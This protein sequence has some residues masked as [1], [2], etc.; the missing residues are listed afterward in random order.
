[1]I[2]PTDDIGGAP[3]NDLVLAGLAALRLLDDAERAALA[4]RLAEAPEI[5]AEIARWQRDL[6]PL[7]LESPP[8]TPPTS[9]WDALAAE[10]G[11]P[12]TGHL[13]TRD[14][15]AWV[16][17]MPG[18]EM[19]ILNVDPRSGERTIIARMQPGSMLPA[20]Q[21]T[22]GEE[23]LIL[24]GSVEVEG[25]RY[26]TGDFLLAGAHTR[27]ATVSAIKGAL[28]LLHWNAVPA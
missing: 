18:V 5:A 23:C 11:L 15:G 19:R 22:Q 28:L 26:E 16:F 13:R 24:E 9:V 21:H 20:H 10:I 1:M 12:P 14:E 6:A 2:K 7:L 25:R 8:V 3:D 4:R 27:H 17:M